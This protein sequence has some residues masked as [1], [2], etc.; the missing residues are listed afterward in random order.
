[1]IDPKLE[2]SGEAKMKD[3]QKVY[4]KNCIFFRRW[5]MDF[6]EDKRESCLAPDNQHDNY[7][8]PNNVQIMPPSVRNKNNDCPFFVKYEKAGDALGKTPPGELGS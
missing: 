4:C 2:K 6:R 7:Y 1:M 5:Y 8:S 3:K